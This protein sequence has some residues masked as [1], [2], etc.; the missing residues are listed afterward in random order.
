LAGSGID[1]VAPGGTP[2]HTGSQRQMLYALVGIGAVVAT[3][4]FLMK[5]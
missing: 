1:Y 4:Y 5:I 3:S 2:G